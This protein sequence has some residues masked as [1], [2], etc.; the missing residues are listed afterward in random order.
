MGLWVFD[1]LVFGLTLY[2]ALMTKT[3]GMVLMNIILRDGRHY[4]ERIS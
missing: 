4:L 3:Q 2:K 1:V